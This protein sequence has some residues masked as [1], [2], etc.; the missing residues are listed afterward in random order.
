M[1]GFSRP[2]TSLRR[3]HTPAIRHCKEPTP[4]NCH[5]EEPVFWATKQSLVPKRQYERE[6]GT[7]KRE[8]ASAETTPPRNDSTGE[9]ENWLSQIATH[10]FVVLAMTGVWCC[11]CK[12]ERPLLSLR[13]A[14]TPH[15]SL[16]GV[17]QARRSN[18]WY[19]RPPPVSPYVIA[20]KGAF[21]PD[22]A[23]SGTE[24]VLGNP[25][26]RNGYGPW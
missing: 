2:T 17:P 25:Q 8:I 20:R 16:R 11:H 19:L 5:C 21:C 7:P 1:Q 10:H 12:E 23:I 26:K 24:G 6:C 13:G 9:H 18:P 3:A 4:P 14:H 15:S 22:A